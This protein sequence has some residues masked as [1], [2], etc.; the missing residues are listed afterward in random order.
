MFLLSHGSTVKYENLLRQYSYS[1]DPNSYGSYQG[2]CPNHPEVYRNLSR[3]ELK[4]TNN[5]IMLINE[6]YK[7]ANLNYGG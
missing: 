7:K 2:S 6:I 1:K 5:V 4:E 3:F